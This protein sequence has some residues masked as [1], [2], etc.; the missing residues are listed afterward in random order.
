MP[1]CL[2][3]KN[4]EVQEENH[5]KNSRPKLLLYGTFIKICS[6]GFSGRWAH[7][8]VAYIILIFSDR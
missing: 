5:V 2:F 1:K 3:N 6:K 8:H 4:F 7:L